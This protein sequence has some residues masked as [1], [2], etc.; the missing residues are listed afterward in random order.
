MSRV[1]KNLFNQSVDNLDDLL[2][3]VT[4][5]KLRMSD[6]ERIKAID[7]IF[8]SIEEQLSFLRYFNS[9]A[10][11]I[12]LQRSNERKDVDMSRIIMGIKW[13]AL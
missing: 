13:F 6:D 1:Y 8:A 5:R 12:S 10:Y 7:N 3:V 4:A 2:M 9:N 11:V